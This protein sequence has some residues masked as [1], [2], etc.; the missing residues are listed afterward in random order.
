MTT[1]EIEELMTE[2]QVQML[3]AEVTEI[4]AAVPTN[5]V[6]LILF[7]ATDDPATDNAK[8]AALRQALSDYR[9]GMMRAGIDSDE[10][11]QTMYRLDAA[12]GAVDELLDAAE[13]DREA[14]LTSLMGKN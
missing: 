2:E 8:Q 6:G 14:L 13:T 11:S 4:V 9:T 10:R 1:H 12:L 7:H 3:A 5:A